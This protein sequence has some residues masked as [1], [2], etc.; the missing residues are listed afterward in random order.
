MCDVCEPT[1]QGFDIN[2]GHSHF[3]ECASW[4]DHEQFQAAC[5]VG[6]ECSENNHGPPTGDA[7]CAPECSWWVVP[8]WESCGSTLYYDD[9]AHGMAPPS[10]PQAM[11]DFYQTCRPV[12]DANPPP[13][14]DATVFDPITASVSGRGDSAEEKVATGEIDLNSS[15]LELVYEGDATDNNEQIIV[16]CFPNVLVESTTAISSAYILFDIDEVRPGQSD[17]DTTINIFGEASA[18]CAAPTGSS[19]DVSSRAA[20]TAAVSWT[21]AASVATHEDLVTP[22]ISPIVR[23]IIAM[24]DWAAGNSLGIMFGHVS[25]TGS[26]WVESSSTN[27]GVD[28]PQLVIQPQ[29]VS[30]SP[31]TGVSQVLDRSFSA[32]EDVTTGA[33]YLDSSDLELMDDGGEQVV[34]IVFPNV[35]IA[36]G[37]TVTEAFVMFDIDEVRPGQS[38]QDVTISIFG[39]ASATPAMPT[40]TASDL[41]SRTPTAANVMWQPE[42]SSVTHEVLTTPNIA[43]IVNEITGLAGWAAGNSLNVMFGHTSGSGVR[44]VEAQRANSALD[45]MSLPALQFTTTGGCG[46]SCAN[47]D[48]MATVTGRPDSAEEAVPAGDMYLDSSDLELVHDGADQQV[49]MV[50]FPNV[51]IAPGASIASASVIFDVDEVRPGQSDA[52]VTIAIYGEASG[53]AAAPSGSASDISSRTPTAAGVIWQPGASV[54]THEDLVTPDLSSI[55]QEIVGLPG[56]TSGSSLAIIMGHI[57]GSG[58]RWV[59]AARENNGIQTPALQWTTTSCDSLI[60]GM[61][62]T[63]DRTWNAEQ[64]VASGEMYLDSS[65]LEL[66]HDGNVEAG[67]EQI[68]LLVFPA[69]DIPAGS[70]V[71]SASVLFDIDEV[72][73]GQS[74]APCL[75]SIMGEASPNAAAPTAAPNDASSRTPTAANVMWQLPAS[76][77]AHEDLVSPDIS[78]IVNE[79]TSLDG[80][81]AGNSLAILMGH[82][83]G[84]G[85]RWVEAARNNNGIDTPALMFTYATLGGAVPQAVTEAYSCTDRTF[86]AEENVGSGAMYLD[87]S[88]LELVHDGADEQVVAVVFTGVT[89]PAGAVVTDARVLFDIDE[90]RPGQSDADVVINIYGEA[91]SNSAAL[92]GSAQ[93]ISSRAPT[94]H[95]VTWVPEASVNAHDD[96]LTPNIA[97]IVQ[98]I[99]G[100]DGWS[101]GNSMGIM[102][103]HISGAGSR[104]V[105]AFSN[106]NGI[107]TPQLQVTY[108]SA[109]GATTDVI[110]ESVDRSTN[111]EEAVASGDMYLDSSDLELMSDGGEQV[112]LVMF[113]TADVPAGATI[114]SAQI[115]FDID[116]VRPGQSDQDCTISISGEL[117][118]S[119]LPTATS[120]DVSSRTTTGAAVLWQPPVSVSTHDDLWTPDL[121]SVVSEIVND[122]SWAAGNNMGF[123]FGY[124]SGSG[125][126]W[127]EAFRNNN[128]VGT[129][130]L[131]ITYG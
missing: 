98:E 57:T 16:I 52:D 68:V 96:L 49:V 28:T 9:V 111:A 40:T 67:N 47:A 44:W 27:N 59:E 113:P 51:G 41:T 19:N 39:E 117:G 107:D 71:M 33:M 100:I 103:G 13:D 24:P 114:A 116:E 77:D 74:D 125:V 48:G 42:S 93:D 88:D 122:G 8:M 84:S 54:A 22:D 79:I 129:P 64:S 86:N 30:C 81:T 78:S 109:L 35:A 29:A 7:T 12:F 94:S 108:Y 119:A 63:A 43:D 127:V 101:S 102:M 58:S 3:R 85:S 37:S 20:T 46:G 45:G 126:R 25:G 18:N 110:V 76:V 89:V 97:S 34:A 23:E 99:V 10:D 91:V 83:S 80:W 50:V 115:L 120:A 26:R 60:D 55:V 4:L 1:Q 112:V 2:P 82:T 6:Q 95:G 121:S 56:W 14:P 62:T 32:E 21:P 128:G 131:Y 61:S 69:V 5:C 66:V 73:P 38:D 123:I 106:N 118:S 87:S 70:P 104:W 36:P 90:V 17:A 15:D 11:S 31:E 65:D 75:V 124:M 130:A 53:N 72:R 105:E 92:S